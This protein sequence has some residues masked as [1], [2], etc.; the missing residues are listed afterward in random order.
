MIASSGPLYYLYIA[1]LSTFITNSV[2]ILLGINGSEVSQALIIGIS[3]ISNDL[4]YIFRGSWIFVYPL[5]YLAA[6]RRWS[7]EGSS[8]QEWHTGIVSMSLDAFSV[9]ILYVSP[10][11]NS[12][13]IPLL[14]IRLLPG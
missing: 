8:M 4:L 14:R 9:C 13:G 6:K 10:A 5:T 7:W 12:P 2:N 11:T 1:L 3:V